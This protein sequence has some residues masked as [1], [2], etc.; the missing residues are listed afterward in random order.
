[1]STPS[2][3]C[4]INLWVYTLGSNKTASAANAY[5]G[6][7]Y[8]QHTLILASIVYFYTYSDGDNINAN[9]KLVALFISHWILVEEEMVE[10]FM[11]AFLFSLC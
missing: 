8:Y 2:G 1:M 10:Y 5:T 4:D 6:A 3:E 9:I 11:T 7:K